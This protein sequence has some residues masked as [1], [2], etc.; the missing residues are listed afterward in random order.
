MKKLLLLGS[1]ILV[2]NLLHAATDIHVDSPKHALGVEIAQ[3]DGIKN[4]SIAF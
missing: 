1:C 4:Y 2:C 3:K